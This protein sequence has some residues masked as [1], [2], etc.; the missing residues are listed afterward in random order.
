MLLACTSLSATLLASP[1]AVMAQTA[2][3][4]P[5]PAG[6]EVIALDQV[7]VDVDVGATHPTHP[8]P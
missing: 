1:S 3:N 2:D 7:V 5:A 4:N 8:T 6:G